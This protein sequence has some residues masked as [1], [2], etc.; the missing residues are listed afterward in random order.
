MSGDWGRRKTHTTRTIH[1]VDGRPIRQGAGPLST[2]ERQLA[3]AAG[4]RLVRTWLDGGDTRQRLR[5]TGRPCSAILDQQR[6]VLLDFIRARPCGFARKRKLLRHAQGLFT[7]LDER[8]FALDSS[9]AIAWAGDGVR[10]DT[11]NYADRVFTAQWAVDLNGLVWLI[12][13][14]RRP[15]APKV[16]RAFVEA[17]TDADI[18]AIFAAIRDPRA[19]AFCKVVA[20]TGCR[21]SEVAYFDWV[22]WH[23]EGRPRSL[24]GYS[25]KV[26]KVFLAV[27]HP[28]EW[29]AGLDLS[30]LAVPGIDPTDRSPSEEV[31]ETNTRHSSRLLKLV[32]RDLVDA[33]FTCRPSWT[34]LR[35]LWTIRAQ[36][37][38][39]DRR[40]AALAQAYG[41]RV[42]AAVYLRHGERRQVLAGIERFDSIL[43]LGR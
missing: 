35:H 16:R 21:P 28:Q 42:A 7:W 34:D 36:A 39:M 25:P 22:R 9:N 15:Q 10:R 4:Q 18:E 14:H 43:Q 5:P 24:S 38:G 11:A 12:P 19:H 13:K 37:D 41:E 2:T 3:L 6:R 8:D 1:G 31:A 23:Q 32:Q 29:L 26:R 20:A 30:L 27:V 17:A 33:G 40:T